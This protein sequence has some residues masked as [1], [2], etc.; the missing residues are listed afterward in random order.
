MDCPHPP[1]P[2]SCAQPPTRG[3]SLHSSLAPPTPFPA[4]P[5]A[6]SGTSDTVGSPSCGNIGPR[7]LTRRICLSR[8]PCSR[9]NSSKS[10]HRRWVVYNCRPGAGLSILHS[11][12]SR[13][14]SG[15]IWPKNAQKRRSSSFHSSLRC[16]MKKFRTIAGQRLCTTY[17]QAG[18]S[19]ASQT[20]R[21]K[22][23]RT[24]GPATSA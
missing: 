15:R 22:S 9:F 11:G 17:R 12:I 18:A 10:L 14:N 5:G 1:P 6:T 24:I 19:G 23:S 8:E 7:R 21:V 20:M 3:S 13:R 16:P 4:A 2:T